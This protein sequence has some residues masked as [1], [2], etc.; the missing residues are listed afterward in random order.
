MDLHTLLMVKQKFDDHKHNSDM[1]VSWLIRSINTETDR[2][3][4]YYGQNVDN[5]KQD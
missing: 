1:F 4:E 3:E 5:A 2:L